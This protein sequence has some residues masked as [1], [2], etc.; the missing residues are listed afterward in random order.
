MDPISTAVL[1]GVAKSLSAKA[2]TW[3]WNKAKESGYVRSL[4]QLVGRDEAHPKVKQ[5]FERAISEVSDN[6]PHLDNSAVKDFFATDD[7]RDIIS[8]WVWNPKR[9]QLQSERLDFTS[10]K[11]RQ[12]RSNLQKFTDR[13]PEAIDHHRKDI[14]NDEAWLIIQQIT[15]EIRQQ[16]EQTRSQLSGK[17][18]EQ[19]QT[20][21]REGQKTRNHMDARL[22]RIERLFH[23]APEAV[24]GGDR[25]KVEEVIQEDLEEIEHLIKR[26]RIEP[27]LELGNRT[28]SRI[29]REGMSEDTHR[30]VHQHLANAYLS[31]LDNKEKALP[32]VQYLSVHAP[33][34]VAKFRNQALAAYLQNN[35]K[36][37]LKLTEEALS[38]DPQDQ[39][40]RL[41]KA[42]A[43]AADGKE[44]DA[45]DFYETT[46][47][48]TD[49]SELYNLG[50]IEI[51]AGRYGRALK[52]AQAGLEQGSDNP[53]LHFL[54]GL[55]AAFR[56]HEMMESSSVGLSEKDR[57]VLDE[58]R[59]CLGQAISSYQD[60]PSR[61]ASAYFYRGVINIQLGNDDRGGEDL[62]R[63]HEL[64]P[65][66]PATLNN[67]VLLALERGD[68]NEARRYF[69]RLRESDHDVDRPT[70]VAL[71]SAIYQLEGNPEV[72][73]EV[74]QETLEGDLSEDIAFRV[75][76]ELARAHRENLDVDK[77]EYIFGQLREERP[78]H[79]RLLA[80][81]G[82]IAKEH[83]D[84]DKAIGKL[85]S[86]SEEAE[87]Q[88]AAYCTGVLAD[89]LFKRAQSTNATED[90][91]EALGL[92]RTR[93]IASS[94]DRAVVREALCLLNLR[95]YSECFDLCQDHLRQQRGGVHST[96]RKILARV[97][98]HHENYRQAAELYKQ[99]ALQGNT[100]TEA[101]LH[102]SQCY[103]MIGEG[104][105]AH[106]AA[107]RVAG[108]VDDS[109]VSDQLML[110]QAYLASGDLVHT[111]H[112][113]YFAQKHGSDNRQ[114]VEYYLSLFLT[115][116]KQIEERD[117]AEEKHIEAFQRL[118]LDYTERYPDSGFLRRVEIPEDPDDLV[119][120]LQEQLPS[121]ERQEGLSDL[122]RENT[123]PVGTVAKLTGK[124]IAEAWAFLAGSR[125]HRVGAN[126]G[127]SNAL[128]REAEIASK[129]HSI[130]LD[131][132]PLLTLHEL[133]VLSALHE[134]FEQI[135]IPQAAFDELAQTIQKLLPGEGESRVFVQHAPDSNTEIS[136][137]KAPA[138]PHDSFL[139]D[140]R[141][142][143][144]F[145]RDTDN[146]GLI[147]RTIGRETD[148]EE[149]V[150]QEE[151]AAER[152]AQHDEIFG[153]PVAEL[154]QEAPL[155]GL[156]VYAEDHIVRKFARSEGADAFGTRALL[157]ALQD[158]DRISNY[159]Y[160][161]ACIRLLEMGYGFPHVNVGTIAFAIEQEGIPAS[162]SWS[163][164]DALRDPRIGDQ[165]LLFMSLQLLLWLWASHTGP[166]RMGNGRSLTVT[167]TWRILDAV[168]KS[169]NGNRVHIA[170]TL[171]D[172]LIHAEFPVAS[173]LGR[174]RWK[175][176]I[177]SIRHWLDNFT[178][179]E[180][181]EPF[182][183]EAT[184]T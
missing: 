9:A 62:K 169:N 19:R 51:L 13:L 8:Q 11:N 168:A 173:D 40:S 107:D 48:L 112:H 60:V 167:W 166:L 175:Q 80:E 132:V 21:E 29:E 133:G 127:D 125:E 3:L 164:L 95:Q 97:H 162:L 31:T 182:A 59:V 152:S 84:I 43:L 126:S 110:S 52:H 172:L 92:Y 128:Q 32:H 44:S 176:M 61:A 64:I 5:V 23:S 113:A 181:D 160:H 66:D 55:S 143:R 144:G 65:S 178:T 165:T 139:Q 170:L 106:G 68:V 18:E 39:T 154:I 135:Y 22:D 73:I 49:A 30:T 33:N 10:A 1:S 28:L 117:A 99:V 134:H 67:L 129:R 122:L 6:L 96:L 72:A 147:G 47:D 156:T 115:R 78:E 16:G 76:L 100:D 41:L 184:N 109:S 7:N 141:K 179:P 120:T 24:S 119:Q 89:L 104:S 71:E 88:F 75:R 103:A 145:I 140:L 111:V 36:R 161:I 91:E 85:R 93:P 148:E 101:L 108:K 74:I 158:A 155:R 171:R 180:K 174:T 38:R 50:Q 83:G 150:A 149:L 87:G 98:V 157:A 70:L 15:T 116:S 105:K 102:C 82:S 131:L 79:P 57:E 12:D 130:I 35:L 37:S 58:A 121:P 4:L 27:A 94:F 86:A 183:E 90:F 153:R 25:N 136:Y 46:A 20:T 151:T 42:H 124:S 56:R 69:E 138:E 159:V 54:Y 123:Y 142:L 45:A 177:E 34:D 163:A 114:C 77:A 81:E 26:K 53:D 146:I 2:T 17:I 118:L 14:F 63:A 137:T